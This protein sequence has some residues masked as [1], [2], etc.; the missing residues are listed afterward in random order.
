MQAAVRMSLEDIMLC[1][2]CSSLK[3]KECIH[4]ACRVDKFTETASKKVAARGW[5]EVGMGNKHIM[6]VQRFSFER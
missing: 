1:E 5:E 4:E 2:I 3:D 6:G